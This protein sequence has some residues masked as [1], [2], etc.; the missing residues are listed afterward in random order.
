MFAAADETVH[1][2]V[3][4]YLHDLLFDLSFVSTSTVAIVDHDMDIGRN[5]SVARW[6]DKNP[7]R[8][9]QR[10]ARTLICSYLFLVCAVLFYTL[11][12]A[13]CY[14]ALGSGELRRPFLKYI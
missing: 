11:A 8:H 7:P 14:Q 5:I 13:I 12:Y 6:H 10:R 4:S 3:L 2:H 9:L 1:R